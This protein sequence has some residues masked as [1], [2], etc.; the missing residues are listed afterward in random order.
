M[1]KQTRREI[2]I[3]CNGKSADDMIRTLTNHAADLDAQIKSSLPTER[4]HE[5]V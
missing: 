2:Y 3:T 1:A 4:Q 5:R